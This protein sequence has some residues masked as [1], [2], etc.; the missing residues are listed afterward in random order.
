MSASSLLGK[1]CIAID[2]PSQQSRQVINTEWIITAMK[3]KIKA[4][5]VLTRK[6]AVVMINAFP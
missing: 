3:N 5:T 1:E 2:M 6:G 4:I